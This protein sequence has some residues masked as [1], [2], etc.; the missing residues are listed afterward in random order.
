[1]SQGEP[2]YQSRAVRAL[3]LLHEQHLRQFM[4][5]WHRACARAVVLPATSDPSYASLDMLAH[6]VLGASRHYVVWTC[7]TLNLNPPRI[8]P[9]PQPAEMPA[10]AERYLEHVLDGWRASLRDITDDQLETP[11]FPSAWKT[12]YSIDA[13]LEHAVMHP[14]RHT[15]QLEELMSSA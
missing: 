3:V 13:M 10:E 6:H 1:M 8:H 7:E 12:R 4:R 9:A 14:V 2:Q 15:F 5:A 11:E